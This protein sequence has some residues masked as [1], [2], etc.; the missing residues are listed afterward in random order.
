MVIHQC[1]NIYFEDLQNL[2]NVYLTNSFSQ[3][4]MS[5]HVCFLIILLY[6]VDAIRVITTNEDIKEWKNF[7]K[8]AEMEC[9]FNLGDKLLM[10]IHF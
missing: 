4:T 3:P 2:Q 6:T 7:G 8:M 5:K 9:T 10:E 1:Q